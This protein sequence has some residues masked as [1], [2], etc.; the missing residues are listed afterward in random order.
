MGFDD[1][2]DDPLGGPAAGGVSVQRRRGRVAGMARRA[3]TRP[4]MA[5]RVARLRAAWSIGVVMLVCCG[6]VVRCEDGGWRMCGMTLKDGAR[7]EKGKFCV[8][9]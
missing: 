3:G 4:A 1:E 5:V 2:A 7:T 9:S 6:G 8:S